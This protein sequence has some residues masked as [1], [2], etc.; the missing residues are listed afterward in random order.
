VFVI[1]P[2][3]DV[4]RVIETWPRREGYKGLRSGTIHTAQG[5]EADVVIFVLGGDPAKEGAKDW[6][7]ETPNLVNV[8]VSRA[9]RRLYV[10]G[11]AESWSKRSYFDVV[12]RRIDHTV[13]YPLAPGSP[14]AEAWLQ[15]F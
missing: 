4:A 7:A 12:D 15:P 6:A 1:T 8:A 13:R 14:D 5:K 9:R 11:H 10:V 3:R 2:F